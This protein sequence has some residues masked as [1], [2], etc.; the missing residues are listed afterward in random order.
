MESLRGRSLPELQELLRRQEKLLGDRKFIS[1]LPDKGKKI[2]DFVEKLKVAIAEEEGL[3][4]TAELLSA[5]RLEF[6][7]NREPRTS[8]M[9]VSGNSNLVQENSADLVKSPTGKVSS[10][11]PEEAHEVFGASERDKMASEILSARTFGETQG[12]LRVFPLGETEILENVS[13][14]Q[15]SE[16]FERISIGGREQEGEAEKGETVKIKTNPFQSVPVSAPR[17]PHY[18][19]VLERRAKNPVA[20]RNKF[21]TNILPADVRCSSGGSPEIPSPG[22]PSSPLSAEERRRRDKKHLDDITAARL[23]PLHHEPAQLLSVEESVAIQVQQK[24]A[25]EEMQAKL[26]AQKLAE[27]LG[28]KMDRFQPEGEMASSYREVKDEDGCSSAED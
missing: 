14:D 28:I 10:K 17:T 24:E 4:R 20:T 16:A 18:I 2:S 13:D 19:E 6:Q 9:V 23:P 1:R 11:W 7:K 27:K 8:N 15:L 25:Y 3:N 12:S 5:V 26:A 21:K 22:G